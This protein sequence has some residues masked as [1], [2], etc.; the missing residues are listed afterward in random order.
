MVYLLH[1]EKWM[2]S[3]KIEGKRD[4]KNKYK[5]QV[6]TILLCFLR[7][8]NAWQTKVEMFFL[9]EWES[10][11]KKFCSEYARFNIGRVT[12]NKKNGAK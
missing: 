5:R 1:K 6:C 9:R 12:H 7:H 4:E 10:N 11:H 8:E 3:Q 2:P